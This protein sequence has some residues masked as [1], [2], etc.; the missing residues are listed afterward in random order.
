MNVTNLP[1]ELIDLCFTFLHPVERAW[2]R[3]VNHIFNEV[4]KKYTCY[5]E[6]YMIY[7]AHQ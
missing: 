4:N 2:L 5:Y 3:Q 1:H 6:D 7:D